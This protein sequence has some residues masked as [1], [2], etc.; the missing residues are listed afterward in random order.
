MR[1]TPTRA[2]LPSRAWSR[3]IHRQETRVTI[4]PPMIGA[5]IGAVATITPMWM[6]TLSL[7]PAGEQVLAD[8]EDDGRTGRAAPALEEPAEDHHG[9]AVGQAADQAGDDEQADAD[10]ERRPPA[11]A[12]GERPVDEQERRSR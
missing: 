1:T 2:T 6:N 8:R 3:K 7:R 10:N 11:V 12:V 5:I 9:R 4:Q